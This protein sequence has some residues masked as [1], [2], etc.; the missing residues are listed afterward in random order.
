MFCHSCVFT[1]VPGIFRSIFC[2]LVF[3]TIFR[4]LVVICRYWNNKLIYLLSSVQQFSFNTNSTVSAR[5]LTRTSTR[6]QGPGQGLEWQGPAPGLPSLDHCLLL[7][8]F[9]FFQKRIAMQYPLVEEV[10]TNP[11][12]QTKDAH[13]A[14]LK[15]RSETVIGRDY[16]LHKVMNTLTLTDVFTLSTRATIFLRQILPKFRGALCGN[17]GS[18]LSPN[19]LHSAASWRC[20]LNWQHFK[21]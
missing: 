6:G 15:S 3:R 10:D 5:T 1:C 18:L 9:E 19:I 16:V 13:E 12:T 8:V 7:Q 21:V 14:F 11:F 4:N 2:N 20:C 17:S